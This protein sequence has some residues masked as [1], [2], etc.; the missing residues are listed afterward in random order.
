MAGIL[1]DAEPTLS[2][3]VV[4]P[5]TDAELTLSRTLVGVGARRAAPT[6]SLLGVDI[7]ADEQPDLS[8]PVDCV[9]T[10]TDA[11]TTLGWTPVRM[12]DSD[13]RRTAPTLGWTLVRIGD[14]DARRTELTLG[15]TPVKTGARMEPMLSWALVKTGAKRTEPGLGW[16]PVRTGDS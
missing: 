6:I 3:L 8:W 5:C 11:E 10:R 9:G 16:A 12:G 13:A 15:W 14:S 1:A 2:R 7:R 4:G